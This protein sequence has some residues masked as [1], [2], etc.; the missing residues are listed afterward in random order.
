MSDARSLAAQVFASMAGQSI[1]A[2][3]EFKQLLWDEGDLVDPSMIVVLSPTPGEV[4]GVAR[5]V[6]RELYRSD[7]SFSCAGFSSICIAPE[8]RG[9]GLSAQ[10]MNAATKQAIELNCD[11]AFLP[12]KVSI[13]LEAH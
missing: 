1:C 11:I 2:S 10:L 13:N 5:L 9:K 7:Q 8:W 12:Y 3:E 4:V 6:V